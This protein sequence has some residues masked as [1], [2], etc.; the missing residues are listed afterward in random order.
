MWGKVISILRVILWKGVRFYT[1]QLFWKIQTY[2]QVFWVCLEMI[3]NFLSYRLWHVSCFST[4]WMR[5]G[6]ER[7][8]FK[9]LNDYKMWKQLLYKKRR[10]W[11]LYM[12]LCFWD[13]TCFSFSRMRHVKLHLRYYYVLSFSNMVIYY[14]GCVFGFDNI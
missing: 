12:T 13:F 11:E 4:L 5:N 7:N 6:S 9:C 8:C 3:H 14:I 2:I 1:M 10:I